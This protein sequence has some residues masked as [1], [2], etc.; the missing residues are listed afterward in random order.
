MRQKSWSVC[1]KN[2]SYQA[3]YEITKH[4]INLGHKGIGFLDSA[5]DIYDC[6]ERKR[7]YQKALEEHGIALLE[8]DILQGFFDENISYSAV[9]AQA[10]LYHRDL[11]T[12]YVAGNDKSAIGCVKALQFL[13]FRVP[14]DISVDLMILNCRGILR[15]PLQRSGIPL[16]SRGVQLWI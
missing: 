3:G 6:S 5:S 11:P 15:H 16:K 4:L 7:G 1:K 13:G 12:A 2:I 14:E 10:H 8:K 9:I